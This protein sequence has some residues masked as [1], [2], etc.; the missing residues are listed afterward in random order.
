[1]SHAVLLVAGRAAELCV[2][3]E[4]RVAVLEERVSHANAKGACHKA[5]GGAWVPVLLVQHC[6]LEAAPFDL[7]NQPTLVR[8][9][10]QDERASGAPCRVHA[11]MCAPSEGVV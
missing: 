9:L 1:M 5:R 3:L 6:L 11:H 10:E 8:A 4:L 7:G 2:G